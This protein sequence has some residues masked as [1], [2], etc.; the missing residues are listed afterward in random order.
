MTLADTLLRRLD[1]PALSRDER[2]SLRCRAAADFEHRGQYEAA[3]E[4]LGDLWR[5]T[6]ERPALEG[7]SERAAAEVLLRAGA[8]SGWLGSVRQI[9]G[10]QDAAKDLI[11][12]SIS[13]FQALGEI[14][15]AA[16]ARGELGFCYRRAGAYD[17]ARVVY[18]EALKE[19]T[20]AGARELRA[21]IILRLAVVESCSGRYNDALRLLT[22]ESRLFGEVDD[23][24]KGRFHNE[25]AC[26]LTVLGRAERRA[27]YL[28]RAV[29]EYT[30]AS[31]Y[32]EQAGH[33]G[34]RASAE[35]NLGF[36][37][38]LVGRYPE[39]HEHLNRARSLFL[40][41]R[42]AGRIAQVDDARAR[43]LLAEGR[44]RE[45]LRASRA[46]V[47]TLEKGG[48]QALLAE[49]LTTQGRALAGAGIFVE[50]LAALRRAA[51]LAE[52][53]G[54]VEDAG[55]AL[56]TLMEEHADR[57]DEREL[58]EAYARADELLKGTQ[59]AE[60]VARLRERAG[61]I[62]GA[63]LP[64]ARRQSARSRASFWSGF[65]LPRR[66]KEFEARYVRRA[67]VEARGS[68][69]RAARLLGYPHH[70]T[71][72]SMLEG[73]HKDLAHLRLPVEP[74][75]RSIMR[76]V[77][78]AHNTPERRA[79]GE[80]RAARILYVED[81]PLVRGAVEDTLK[82]EGWGVD[83]CETAAAA[84]EKLSVGKYYD[85][86]ITDYDMP[87][88]DGVEFV[89]RV[90]ETKSYRRTPIIML[91]ASPVATEAYRAGVNMVLRKPEGVS[92][93]TSVVRRM[94]LAKTAG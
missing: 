81:D 58:L 70:G 5:G 18:H 33:T 37:L 74:R 17:E 14:G 49:A 69:T 25:L 68:I 89:R 83:A 15:R 39:A 34:Y 16:E 75:R 1:D 59:D 26:A 11:S 82:Y 47:R 73:R 31:H 20:G 92:G 64:S 77:R 46:A 19:L 65:D 53:V 29:I 85:L 21:R 93:L 51:R 56:L 88:M 4:A 67:L 28:D 13:R 35:N 8:L 80:A 84:L 40:A 2:A 91:T 12:E 32:F 30:A 23:A 61:H 42:E 86:V 55:L 45:A 63:R 44:T 10:A 60:T 3:R 41:A 94:I 48:E 22:D 27:D 54:A 38:H 52:E 9:E 78:G 43:V 24:L 50:S 57:L 66:V 87:G 79:G 7:L 90:R 36:L 72:Q 6:G 71:L 62:I 76:E